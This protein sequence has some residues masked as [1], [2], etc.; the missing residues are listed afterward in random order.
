MTS[1]VTVRHP[2]HDNRGQAGGQVERRVDRQVRGGGREPGALCERVRDQAG[3]GAR[4]QGGSPPGQQA[5]GEKHDD[6]RSGTRQADDD[7]RSPAKSMRHERV[8]G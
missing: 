1:P 6:A 8:H 2:R 3:A 4:D 5:C 7:G